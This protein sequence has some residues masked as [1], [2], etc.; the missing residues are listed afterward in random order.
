MILDMQHGFEV[1]S[2]QFLKEIFTKNW[3]EVD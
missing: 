3:E 2:V 1:E